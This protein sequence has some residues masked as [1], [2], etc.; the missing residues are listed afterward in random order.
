MKHK[1]RIGADI[2]V[3]FILLALVFGG[4]LW[5][6]YREAY[7]IPATPSVKHSTELAQKIILMFGNEQG[8]LVPEGREIDRC[9]E[10]TV[11]LKAILEELFS[12][13]IGDLVDIF[14]E[15]T[16]IESVSLEGDLAVID[17]GADF[18]EGLTSGSSAEM[19]AVY[20]IVNTVSANF[21]EIKR[22]QIAIE[23][24]RKAHL[25]HLDL[26]EPL[27]PDS[28]LEAPIAPSNKEN[29]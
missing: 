1:P 15:W 17:L 24:N 8:Q 13:P 10:Q 3:P 18:V 16:S 5:Q 7:Q 28:K 6:K 21:P 9:K 23:G 29:R 11:C 2:V 19:L 25:K 27:S 4:M 26:S 12:G 20:G 14:P 22:V